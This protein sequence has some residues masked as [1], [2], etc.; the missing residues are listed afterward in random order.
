MVEK[1]TDM[2]Y[3]QKSFEHAVV[4]VD[5]VIFRVVDHKLEVLLLELNRSEFPGMWAAPGGLVTKSET[6]EE[7]ATRHLSDRA[8]LKNIYLEQLSTFG[9]PDRDPTGWVV[10][11]AYL[12]LVTGE[13]TPKTNDQYKS[14]AWYP[15][16][17]LPPLAYD[18][19]EIIK[20]A[21]ERLKAKITYTNIVV[22][23]LPKEFTL[24][25]LQETYE[26]ILSQTLDKRNFRKK[27]LSLGWLTP[28]KK[29]KAEGAHRPAEL[30]SFKSRTLQTVQVL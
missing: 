21:V 17:K 24:T 20:I 19:T 12:A 11:V 26:T 8:G 29:M 18:H 3:P 9:D 2:S 23:L 4:A 14:I 16:N 5:T 7:A 10:S 25:E 15:V 30:Y 28:L 27:I 13:V 6:L 1:I 22:S